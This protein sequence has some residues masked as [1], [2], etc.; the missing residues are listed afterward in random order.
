MNA[1]GKTP[2]RGDKLFPAGLAGFGAYRHFLGGAASL[3]LEIGLAKLY[4]DY[5]DSNQRDN[6]PD[7]G[8]RAEAVA[9]LAGTQ[10]GADLASLIVKRDN[11]DLTAQQ[12]RDQIF[13]LLCD[14]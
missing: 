13:D 10:A 4:Q 9:E 1:F 7:P 6:D 11:G 12:L 3:L 14:K 2:I 8:R 5:S